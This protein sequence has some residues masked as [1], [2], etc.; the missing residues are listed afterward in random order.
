MLPSVAFCELQTLREEL[1]PTRSLERQSRVRRENVLQLGE[2]RVQEGSQ[3]ALNAAEQ[4][5]PGTVRAHITEGAQQWL[6]G[7]CQE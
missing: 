1:G 5:G 3:C 2:E 6:V 7:L 4:L